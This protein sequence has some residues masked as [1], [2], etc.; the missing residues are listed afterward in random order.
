[1]K[2]INYLISLQYNVN[3]KNKKVVDWFNSSGNTA[4]PATIQ[5][6]KDKK[7]AVRVMGIESE[8]IFTSETDEAL[9][10]HIMFERFK[11]R[12]KKTGAFYNSSSIVCFEDDFKP[13][14][15]VKK[16]YLI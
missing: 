8:P 14:F 6:F 16:A 3:D 1:M 5:I 11:M 12:I 9:I 13:L 2:E 7:K 4:I 10:L 15:I